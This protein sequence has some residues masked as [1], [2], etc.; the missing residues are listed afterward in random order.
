L[1]TSRE[2][3]HFREKWFWE[4][5]ALI[6]GASAGNWR[7]F[8]RKELGGPAGTKLVL[9]G[10]AAKD[11][12]EGNWRRPGPDR[13]L[14]GSAPR[15]SLLDLADPSAPEKIFAFTKE[16]KG[17][18]NR[19]NLINNAGFSVQYGEF[20]A[21]EKQCFARHGAGK[22]CHA[23]VH[24]TR[25]VFA[26]NGSRRRGAAMCFILASNRLLPKPFP[27]ISTLCC[28][29]RPFDSAVL[30]KGWP[31]R[32]NHM[33]SALCALCPGSTESEFSRCFPAR[34]K[35]QTPVW[36]QQKKSRAY[37]TWKAPGLPAKSYV[38]SGLGN[39]PRRSRGERLVP[40]AS[41]NQDGPGNVQ[42]REQI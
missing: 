7:G 42:A 1:F 35:F 23:V 18:R 27:Y 24:L 26:G 21:V 32:W 34:K 38:I 15:C 40:G 39:Y 17:I 37:R 28:H 41:V 8:S 9:T 31:K 3:H 10:H 36:R 22:N 29:K 20:T 14:Q 13:N 12:L 25:L 19:S 5:G 30:Q 11:R 4:N 2:G 33:E 6:T 16:R